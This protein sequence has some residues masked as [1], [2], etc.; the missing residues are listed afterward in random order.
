M[1]VLSQI[2]KAPSHRHGK[3]LSQPHICLS[4]FISTW[5]RL[6]FVSASLLRWT[7]DKK[8]SPLLWKPLP[9]FQKAKWIHQENWAVNFS[10]TFLFRNSWLSTPSCRKKK[11][12]GKG[13]TE[14]LIN[15]CT[16]THTEDLKSTFDSTECLSERISPVKYRLCVKWHP[17]ASMLVVVYVLH[18]ICYSILRFRT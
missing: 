14:T 4:K 10:R 7:A 15:A 6:C 9:A 2:P 11:C 1:N 18:I 3:T 5:I 17:T 8:P 13:F 12:T 16:L